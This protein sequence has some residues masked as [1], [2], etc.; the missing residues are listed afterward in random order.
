MEV[1]VDCLLQC[2]YRSP[3]SVVMAFIAAM[4]RWETESWQAMRA[5]RNTITPDSYRAEVNHRM[6]RI[7]QAYCTDK[8]RPH[9]RTG[10]FQSPP[11]CDPKKETVTS[12]TVEKR[13]ALV[14]TT[15]QTV[16]G[17]GEYRY[18]LFMQADQWRID[19]LKYKCGEKW[20]KA[21]L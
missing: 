18:V 19:N 8:E 16:L 6:I 11:E 12:T 9:G 2:D 14:E 7:F 13:K 5:A 3:A 20:E 21:I 1:N 4:N 17:G 15:R 10:S